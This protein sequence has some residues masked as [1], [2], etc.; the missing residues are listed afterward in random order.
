MLDP[1][2]SLNEPLFYLHHGAIDYYWS[3]WQ[4]QDRK[5]NLYDLDASEKRNLGE[6]AGS[7]IIEMGSFA[8][9]RTARQVADPENKDGTGTLCFRYEGQTA[10]EYL[11]ESPPKASRTT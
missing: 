10:K 6:K 4:E 9:A 1:L 3:I 7:V 5:N 8:P 11:S 2:N